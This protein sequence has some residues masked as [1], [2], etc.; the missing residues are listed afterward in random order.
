M[1]EQEKIDARLR[2][3]KHIWLKS[4]KNYKAKSNHPRESRSQHIWRNLLLIKYNFT[5]Q[6][7]GKRKLRIHAH[8]IK[9]FT[10]YPELRFKVSNGVLL[11][12]DCH[13]AKHP[14]L[15]KVYSFS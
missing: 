1:N 4:S 9:S 15:A 5:C 7:C 13:K 3:L 11:C 10:E 12:N 2:F 14:E 6:E 8:H